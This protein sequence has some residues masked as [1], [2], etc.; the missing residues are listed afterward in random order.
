MSLQG[1]LLRGIKF[2]QKRWHPLK[3]HT[4]FKGWTILFLPLFMWILW[5][6]LSHNMKFEKMKFGYSPT[7]SLSSTMNFPLSLS[8]FLSSTHPIHNF[9]LFISLLFH[10]HHTHPP[11][12]HFPSTHSP[13]SSLFPP[14]LFIPLS[15]FSKTKDSTMRFWMLPNNIISVKN[16][17][18]VTLIPQILCDR[19]FSP[20]ISY[21]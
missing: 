8:H 17:H 19:S 7:L 21:S 18:Q 10:F 3:K 15:L 20:K 12:L 14:F 16:L 13:L 11:F 5:N 1:I 6:S 2:L 4:T 9:P